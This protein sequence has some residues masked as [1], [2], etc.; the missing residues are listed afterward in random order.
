MIT[1]HQGSSLSP[2][3]RK[4]ANGDPAIRPNP[5]SGPILPDFT[6]RNTIPRPL[7]YPSPPSAILRCSKEVF[8]PEQTSPTFLPFKSSL[9]R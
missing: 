4:K 9:S 8:P 2:I 3:R 6:D 1:T 7:G 5:P